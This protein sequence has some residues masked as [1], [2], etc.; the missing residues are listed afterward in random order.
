MENMHSI[1]VGIPA[2]EGTPALNS[3]HTQC[4]GLDSC[5]ARLSV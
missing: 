2:G 3:V 5:P 4:C 1:D